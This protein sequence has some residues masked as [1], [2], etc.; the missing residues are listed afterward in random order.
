MT[1][2]KPRTTGRKR[3]IIAA[4]VLLGLGAL[5][6]AAYFTDFANINL[7]GAADGSG[8][9]GN[10]DFSIS[11]G[12]TDTDGVL[13]TPRAWVPANTSTGIDYTID[14]ADALYPGGPSASVVIPVKNTSTSLASIVKLKIQDQPGPPA[15]DVDMQNALR[16]TIKLN[17]TQ[18]GTANMT[19]TAA[20]NL[21]LFTAAAP[22]EFGDTAEIEVIVTLP[23]QTTQALDDALNGLTA[24][25]R[26]HLDAQSTA[27][28]TP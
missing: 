19:Q 7:N 21:D 1:Q 24:Y 6:T 4:G 20:A 14:G 18:V 17:G 27:S 16:Y 5:T 11:V 3:L 8:I 25:V 12:K 13:V 2:T 26:V 10:N 28:V 22:L 23:N 15:S 9:G